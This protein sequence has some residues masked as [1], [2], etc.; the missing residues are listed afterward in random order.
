M[1]SP[2]LVHMTPAMGR[3]V[4]AARAIARGEVLGAFHTI[5]LPPH[6]VTAMAATTLSHFWFEDEADGAAFV[7]LGLFVFL[8]KG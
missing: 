7:V 5:R 2:I 1:H 6:E 8:A 3:G 4:F